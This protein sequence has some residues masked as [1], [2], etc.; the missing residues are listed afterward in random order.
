MGPQQMLQLRVKVDLELMK[1]NVLSIF[2]KFLGLKHLHLMQLSAYIDSY[3]RP[4]DETLS[5]TTNLSKSESEST[6]NRGIL[7]IPQTPRQEP[8]YQMSFNVMPRT[9]NGFKYCKFNTN[10]M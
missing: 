8:H 1:M 2:P 7:H 9:L 6:C 3:I 5:D 4:I 10:N